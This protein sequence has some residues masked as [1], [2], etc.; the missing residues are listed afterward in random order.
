MK[1]LV[2]AIKHDDGTR[3]EGIAENFTEYNQIWAELR[4]NGYSDIC[5]RFCATIPTVPPQPPSISIDQRLEA[6][7][8]LIEARDKGY[9]DIATDL[10]KYLGM[11]Q[12]AQS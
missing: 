3:Y 4:N 11:K 8:M 12:D 5:V 6:T 10:E 7:R 1:F 2:T 9:D